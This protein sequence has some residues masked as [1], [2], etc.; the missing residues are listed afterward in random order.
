MT[1]Q[2]PA[3]HIRSSVDPT[4]F[5]IDTSFNPRAA[6][7]GQFLPP[8]YV[9]R[10]ISVTRRANRLNMTLLKMTLWRSAL[11]YAGS[12][13]CRRVRR[14]TRRRWYGGAPVSAVSVAP[15]AGGLLH[16]ATPAVRLQPGP[17]RPG[18]GPPAARRVRH[19]RGRPRARRVRGDRL[20]SLHAGGG[21]RV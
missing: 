12:A 19:Q 4:R 17:V 14:E 1:L 8:L 7:R 20:A 15:S 13:R 18:G 21:G 11:L 3:L 16:G 9:C 2:S 6:G 10:D 5:G